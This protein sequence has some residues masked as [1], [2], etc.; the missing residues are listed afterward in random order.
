MKLDIPAG[1]FAGYLFDLDGTL[2]DTMPLHYRAWDAALR[3]F[4]LDVPLDEDMFYGLGGVPTR[5]VAEIMGAHYGLKLDT[6]QVMT[7]KEEMYL[8]DMDAVTIIEPVAAIARRVAAEGFPV[9]IVT[10]G[11]PEVVGPALAAAGLKAL[12]KTVIT[13]LDVPVGRGKPEP[14]MFL[15]AAKRMGVAPG[16]CLV[17]EDAEPGLAGARAAGMQVVHVP[18]R[19]P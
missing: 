15:L 3:R 2:V 19:R 5:Q 6:D 12:F 1:I 9:A 14:D 18:S 8:K 11:T 16:S 10:G 17:F 4:G 13:P 7:V